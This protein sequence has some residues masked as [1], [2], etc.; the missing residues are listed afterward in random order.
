MDKVSRRKFMGA[1]LAGT[2][3]LT[4]KTDAQA[5][6][7]E[8][9]FRNP[10]VYRFKIGELEAFSISDCDIG[11]REGLDLMWPEEARA[12]M[13]EEMLRSGETPGP[14]PLYAN[15]LVV[16]AGKDVA[17]FDA[18]FGKVGNPKMGWLLEGLAAVGISPEQVTAGFL[19]HAHADHL[20]GF[21]LQG[22]PAF[23]N[24]TIHLLEEELAFWRSPEPDF[25]KSK[26]NKNAIPG[27]I[28]EVRRNFDILGEKLRPAKGGT[29][30]LGGMV[31]IES[32][33]GHTDGHACFRIRS[34]ADELLH[35]MDLAHH[36][37]LMFA[38]P[39][40]TIA[41]DHD[42]VTAVATR[43]KY[44]AEAVEKRTRCF[45]FHLP[46]PGLGH[47]TAEGNGFLW[48]PEPWRWS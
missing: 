20:N 39:N 9:P 2:A 26:R 17:L 1:A 46:W 13:K 10:F 22:K 44:W 6:G 24:A 18:G 5:S 27:M 21:I 43:K 14:L 29:E 4:A 40:W 30:V 36:P 28:Q 11:M 41:F 37:L 48:R 42:P 7:K 23:P 32:A 35:L 12:K 8:T 15:I 31:R 45:G 38:D 3:A 47:I 25:S 19:S 33:P 16:R 34:G